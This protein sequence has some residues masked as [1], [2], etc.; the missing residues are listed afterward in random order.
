MEEP[1][2]Y[3]E[4]EVSSSVDNEEPTVEVSEEV[5]PEQ[6]VIRKSDRHRQR[7]DYYGMGIQSEDQ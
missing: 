4:L 5:I 2:H 1:I 3:I 6:P 7:P